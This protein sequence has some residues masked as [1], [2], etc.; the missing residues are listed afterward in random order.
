M[1]IFAVKLLQNLSR[2][3]LI[4]DY[5]WSWLISDFD[6]KNKFTDILFLIIDGLPILLRCDP[7]VSFIET[8]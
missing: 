4:V 2:G 1:N 7:A 3:S 5:V 8:R 6:N